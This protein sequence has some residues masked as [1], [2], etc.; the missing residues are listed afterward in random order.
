MAIKNFVLDTNV[1]LYDPNAIFSFEDNNVIIPIWVVEEIDRFKKDINDTGRNARELSRHLDAL[2]KK[3]DITQGVPLE[4]GGQ[5]Q[6]ITSIPLSPDAP[7]F[8]KKES[9]DNLILATAFYLKKKNPPVIF[10][11]KDVNLRIKADA[12]GIDTMD[13]ETMRIEP[14]GLYTGW[15]SLTVPESLISDFYQSKKLDTA[16]LPKNN[17]HE[18]EFVCLQGETN[19]SQ[20][21]LGI[22]R[23]GEVQLLPPLPPAVWGVKP[24]NLEQQ[25]ALHLL[26]DDR[27]PLVTLTGK[28]GTGK[29]LLALAAGMAKTL[30][31][32]I[33]Q[34]VL[35]SRPIFPIGRDIGYLPGDVKEKL[36]PWMQPIFDN[37]EFL[38]HT[39]KNDKK[40][41][42][43]N[44][45][46]E[47]GLLQIEALT[48][49]RGRSIP[50]QY[51]IVD[52]AQNMTPHEAKT[53]ITR[54]GEHTKIIFTGDIHQID[55][56]Y[57]DA[58][59]NG[60]SYIVEHL[61]AE[62]LAGHMTLTK[63]ERS[64]LAELA[65]NLL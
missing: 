33:Y 3:G 53:V 7:E 25:F 48:Y 17:F 58:S 63:G 34:R 42:R 22:Y 2:R 31:E 52:E 50:N 60:L 4:S 38:L 64:A 28:A 56:F 12:L 32:G 44:A 62:G 40:G 20:S 46:I 55:N 13:Y 27:I 47:Q 15:K 19:A 43:Y 18:N 23:K 24:R 57:N 5:L 37:M 35:V 51:F 61:K 54:V 41:P 49:I 65:S 36:Q 10:I 8:L 30:D 11:T 14:E 16:K 39:A 6:V 21:A 45:L 29:T 9:Y 26:L 1:V 59:H